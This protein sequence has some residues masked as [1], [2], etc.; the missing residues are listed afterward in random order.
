MRRGRSRRTREE[1]EEV[2]ANLGDAES[3]FYYAF[4]VS[5]YGASSPTIAL[6]F[7]LLFSSS[8]F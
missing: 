5:F 2:D 6:C 7:G 1:E 3:V 4:S 8:M